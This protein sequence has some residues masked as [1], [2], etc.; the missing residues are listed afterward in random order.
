MLGFDDKGIDI[1][2]TKDGKNMIVQ[3]K[4][5]KNPIGPSVVRELY[6]TLVSSKADEAI[7]ASISGFTAG[8]IE[9]VRDKPIKLISLNDILEMQKTVQK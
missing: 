9:F 3:C 8:V 6:G 7:L 4:A 1:K 2:L 5:H